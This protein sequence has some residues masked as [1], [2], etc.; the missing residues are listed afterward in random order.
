MFFLLC[1]AVHDA[2][3]QEASMQTMQVVRKALC[4][5]LLTGGRLI[6]AFKPGYTKNGRQGLLPAANA[7][8]DRKNGQMMKMNTS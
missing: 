7:E 3:R 6:P 8:A 4:T 1:A 5:G 2:G